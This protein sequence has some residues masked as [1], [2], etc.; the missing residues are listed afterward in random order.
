MLELKTRARS[1]GDAV[2]H[3]GSRGKMPIGPCA[4]PP[5][6]RTHLYRY[7]KSCHLHYSAS[8]FSEDGGGGGG[9]E[10]RAGEIALA[11][12]T[13]S[14]PPIEPAL[15]VPPVGPSSST[16]FPFL[17]CSA[18]ARLLTGDAVS[19]LSAHS[20][21]LSCG[22]LSLPNVD[23]M[24]VLAATMH[25]H[26][27]IRIHKGWAH[28]HTHTHTHTTTRGRVRRGKSGLHFPTVMTATQST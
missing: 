16:P 28:T 25:L 19:S 9:Y 26:S 20:L 10:P 4:P 7:H 2:T 17:P 23:E 24:P 8:P 11:G 14:A 5:Q 18:T 3:A 13:L 22:L 12:G 6:L 1:Y 15:L 27:H 21:L